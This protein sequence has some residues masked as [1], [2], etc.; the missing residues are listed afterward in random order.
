M[1]VSV[2]RQ[3]RLFCKNR[4]KVRGKSSSDLA[5][6]TMT[7]AMRRQG[8][9]LGQ[10]L[11]QRPNPRQTVPPKVLTNARPMVSRVSTITTPPSAVSVRH[12]MLAATVSSLSIPTFF[13][14]SVAL[15]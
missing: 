14:A 11:D 10:V 2:T 12:S 3:K 6:V 4:A 1:P 8:I 7:T 5:V 15:Q 13:G 9:L